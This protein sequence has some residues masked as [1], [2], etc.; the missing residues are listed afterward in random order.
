MPMDPLSGAFLSRRGDAALVILSP[1]RPEIDPAAGRAVLA[2]SEAAG[3]RL[4][5]RS[6]ARLE[7]KARGGPIYAAQ[8]EAILR[9][10]LTR[11]ASSTVG[12]VAVVLLAGFEGLLLPAAILAA[13]L[14]GLL[15]TAGAVGLAMPAISVVGVGFAAAPIG[16]GVDYGNHGRGPDPPPAPAGGG[17]STH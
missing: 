4:R 8:D 13:V 11:T 17:Q 5:S 3:A 14:A 16:V 1:S 15:W 6:K 12:G 2:E 10:D 7:L 9:G